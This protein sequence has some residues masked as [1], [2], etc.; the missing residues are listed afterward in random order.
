[1]SFSPTFVFFLLSAWQMQKLRKKCFFASLREQMSKT[2]PTKCVFVCQ[3]LSKSAKSSIFWVFHFERKSLPNEYTIVAT[4]FLTVRQNTEKNS[5]SAGEIK[6]CPAKR[7]ILSEIPRAD[8]TRDLRFGAL[9][10][11]KKKFCFLKVNEGPTKQW[12]NSFSAGK[13]KKCPYLFI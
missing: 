11:Q 10:E 7:L 2:T 8:R 4:R 13:I 3:Y 6:K 1:M 9:L 12:K 5:F